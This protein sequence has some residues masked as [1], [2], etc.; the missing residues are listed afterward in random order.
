MRAKDWDSPSPSHATGLNLRE[1]THVDLESCVLIGNRRASNGVS[2]AV[3]GGGTDDSSRS[4]TITNCLFHNWGRVFNVQSNRFNSCTLINNIFLDNVGI[5]TA[6]SSS[7]TSGD[8]NYYDQGESTSLLPGRT[9]FPNGDGANAY[10]M[11]DFANHDFHP[12]GPLNFIQN[13]GV[14]HPMPINDLDGNQFDQ[15]SPDL[16]PY[17][18]PE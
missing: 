1:T 16:G 10:D 7:T 8:K 15:F 12:V 9:E 17:G 14:P 13:L 4:I 5:V 2:R 3:V 18:V 6:L 11:V